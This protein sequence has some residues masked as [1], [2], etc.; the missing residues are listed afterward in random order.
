M[1]AKEARKLATEMAPIQAEKDRI[2]AEEYKKYLLNE[3]AKKAAEEQRI[4]D[5]RYAKIVGQIA[6]AAKKGKTEAQIDIDY[7]DNR[8]GVLK[9]L[10]ADGYKAH[11][12]KRYYTD[13][14]TDGDGYPTESYTAEK[15]VYKVEW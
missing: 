10:H 14:Y 7:G 15:D 13:H 6:W 11:Q 9:R 5:E 4:F 2:A 12:S 8:L 1:N 3:A